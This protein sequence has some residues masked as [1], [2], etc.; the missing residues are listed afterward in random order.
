MNHNL[1]FISMQFRKQW[2]GGKHFKTTRRDMK[3]QAISI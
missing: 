3:N 1:N 2:G